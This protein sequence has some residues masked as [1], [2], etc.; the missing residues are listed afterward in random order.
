MENRKAYSLKSDYRD[1]LA[2]QANG[3]NRTHSFFSLRGAQKN[4][5]QF[6]IVMQRNIYRST[7]QVY[8]TYT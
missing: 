1:L 4:A 5:P 2:K 3:I 7:S 8:L 6:L